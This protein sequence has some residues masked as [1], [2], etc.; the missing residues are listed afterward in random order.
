MKPR[1]SASA[2]RI[3]PVQVD[4]L[5]LADGLL[6]PGMSAVD[7]LGAL[8]MLAAL[9]GR[10]LPV[11]GWQWSGADGRAASRALPRSG[12]RRTLPQVVIVPG[13]HARSG[14]DLDRL[15]RRDHF[16]ATRLRL[17]HEAG[18]HILG[19]Y[20]G[21]ALLAAAGLLDGA[22]AALPWP[23]AGS[24]LRHA[25]T[26]AGSAE[27][28]WARHG[29]VWT[30]DSPTALTEVLLAV[31]DALG[32]VELAAS[33]GHVLLHSP[34]R[35]RLAGPA[36]SLAQGNTGRGA[37]VGPG[38]VEQARRWLDD[39]LGQ[40]Y[41]LPTLAQA[42]ATSSRSL[43]RHFKA[44]LGLTP[45]QY[46]HRARATQARMLLETSYLT[47]E[48][49]AQRCGYQDLAMFRRVFSAATGLTP[50]AYRERFRL[51]TRRREWGRDLAR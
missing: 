44:A 18:A 17:A 28:A 34:E 35:A 41:R 25:P 1:K 46:L 40:P 6:G 31:L 47:V 49:I 27:G 7:T 23:F 32:Q 4:I 26:L 42:C 29:R 2:G 38:T 10:R 13:W 30:C 51:R 33:T 16:A 5:A 12:P 48:S 19:V 50:A 24:V 11:A 14:P 43:L 15:V 36:S 21:V 37:R 20:T 9:R 45:L 22:T 8:N 39:H 3:R